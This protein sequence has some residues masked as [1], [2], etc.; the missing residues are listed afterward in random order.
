MKREL[1]VTKDGSHTMYVKE[2]DESYHSIHGALQESRYVF[3]NQ[4]YHHVKKSPLFILEA[5]LGTGL[6]LLL[7]LLESEKEGKEVYYHTVE[8]YPLTSSE[9]QRLNYE[10]I[11]PE[12][13]SGYLQL[14]HDAPWGQEFK[15]TDHFRVYKEN[16][17]FRYMKPIRAFDLIYFDAFAPD[18]Q[19]HLWSKEMFSLIADVAN[20]GC[21]L[22][23][24]S[25][26]GSVCRAL[27]SNGFEV[28][29]I[30]GPPGKR[31]MIRAIRI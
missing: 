30:P 24:Y 31:E 1:H 2:L 4:G 26:K 22:V 29:K 8:K 20:P 21:T 16:S 18:K 6:N 10:E 15:M 17:D 27:I 23:T 7:T 5:G 13:P 25:A 19:P 28:E 3:I 9:V 14:L 12:I 11:I